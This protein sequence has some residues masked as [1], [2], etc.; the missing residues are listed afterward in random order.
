MA[1]ETVPATP[2]I[3]GPGIIASS[4]DLHE[5]AELLSVG[6]NQLVDYGH[7]AVITQYQRSSR[8]SVT[9]SAAA[10]KV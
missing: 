6:A 5:G 3:V 9:K 7:F 10:R 1:W 8:R 2:S 4:K